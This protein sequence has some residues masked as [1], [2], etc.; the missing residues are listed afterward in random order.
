MFAQTHRARTVAKR[1]L[2]QFHASSQCASPEMVSIN[3]RLQS[4][5]ALRKTDSLFLRKILATCSTC[6]SLY[7][8]KMVLSSLASVTLLSLRIFGALAQDVRTP[9]QGHISAK[10]L[11]IIP[12]RRR[13][14]EPIHLT[15]PQRKSHR[16]I[17]LFRNLRHQA[18][19]RPRHPSPPLLHQRGTRTRRREFC[20]RQPLDRAS[21]RKAFSTPT[22][23]DDYEIQR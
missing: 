15:Q 19:Q 6:I 23:P 5:L 22:E 10:Q 21:R 1:G 18:R 4:E 11:T 2:E 7:K 9:N 14:Q 20:R 12:G 17:P 3:V 13:S 16:T 8:H